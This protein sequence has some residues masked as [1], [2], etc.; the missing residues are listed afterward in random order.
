MTQKAVWLGTPR[1]KKQYCEFPGFSLC[2]YIP[3]CILGNS[4]LKNANRHTQKRSNKSLLPQAKGPG[5]KTR[6]T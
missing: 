5:K 4:Q 1:H 2:Q 3:D 6:Y